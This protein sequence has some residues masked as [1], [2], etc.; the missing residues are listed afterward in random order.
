[1][2]KSQVLHIGCVGPTDVELY[3]NYLRREVYLTFPDQRA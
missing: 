2:V 1:M 3:S